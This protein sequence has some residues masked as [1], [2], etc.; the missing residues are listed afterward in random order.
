[1]RHID[2]TKP[3]QGSGT[4]THRGVDEMIEESLRDGSSADGLVNQSYREGFAASSG[5]RPESAETGGK[6]FAPESKD[7]NGTGRTVNSVEKENAGLADS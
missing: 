2:T 4:A 5:I 7:S 1:M 3:D 6:A